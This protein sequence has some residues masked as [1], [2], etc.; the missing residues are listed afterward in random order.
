MFILY[1]IQMSKQII[2]MSEKVKKSFR[3]PLKKFL[4]V[5]LFLILFSAVLA[6]VLYFYFADKIYPGISVSGISISGLTKP[7]AEAKLTQVLAN[8]LSSPITFTHQNQQFQVTPA[9]LKDSLNISEA[10]ADAYLFGHQKFYFSRF[11]LNLS[12][13]QNNALGDQISEIKKLV[14]QEPI[15]AQ[16]KVEGDQISVTPSQEG[17][18]LDEEGLKKVLTEYINTGVLTDDKLPLKKALPELS[19]EDGLKIKEVLDKV[20]LSPLQLTFKD[21]K[22]ILDFNTLLPIIDLEKS[23]SVLVSASILASPVT[24]SSVNVNGQNIT[25]KQISLNREKLGAFLN[26]IASQIDRPVKEPLL[27]VEQNPASKTPRVTEFSPPQEGWKLNINS[28][29][30]KITR[31]VVALGQKNSAVPAEIPLA[32]DTI[33]PKNKLSN[34]LGI[35]ELIGRGVSN[36]AGSIPNRIYNVELAASRINGVLIAPGETFSFV[37]TIGDISATT[38]Y[39][40]AYVIKSGRTVL[41]DGGG[42]CQVSTTLFRAILNSGMP[43]VNRVAHAYRVSYYEQ[44]YP[45]GLDA[46]IY[47]PSVDLKFKNDS[48]AH[49]LIQSYA[50]GTTLYVDFYGTSDGRTAEVSRPVITNQTPAPPELRQDDPTLPKGTVKQVDFAAA[51][52]NVVFSRTVKKNGQV[53]INESFKSNYRPWQAIYLVGTKE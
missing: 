52:A 12:L 27:N 31:E 18:V 7:E 33:Q 10:V 2:N 15:N 22:F 20:K 37:N 16:L 30:D 1:T 26:T 13:T 4:F 39:K 41:D 51:G 21:Q 35:K 6:S 44:G 24:V 45:P 42:V 53:I 47:S 17:V 8:K 23:N 32:V 40:Q 50:V 46:T 5:S 28:S 9:L 3:L 48:P 38:G 11:N 34:E 19:Y 49:I 14:D 29:S 36:Y 25:D 43:V